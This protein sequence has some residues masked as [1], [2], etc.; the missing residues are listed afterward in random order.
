M[1]AHDTSSV[2]ELTLTLDF[3]MAASKDLSDVET[4]LLSKVRSRAGMRD[5]ADRFF[6]SDARQGRLSKADCG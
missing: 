3:D 6:C 5:L 1:I 4:D 2:K